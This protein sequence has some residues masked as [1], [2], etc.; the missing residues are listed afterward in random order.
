MP[1][2][3]GHGHTGT[4]VR[5][6]GLGGW[7]MD[8]LLL[9]HSRRD[10]S[11]GRVSRWRKDLESDGDIQPRPPGPC[12]HRWRR[13]SHRTARGLRLWRVRGA[14]RR[15][16]LTPA[17]STPGPLGGQPFKLLTGLQG[18]R[19]SPDGKRLVAMR[20]GAVRGDELIVADNDGGNP[21]A[22]RTVE[23]W[24]PCALACL[25]ARRS[26][27]LLRL[28]V[29]DHAGGADRTLSRPIQRKRNG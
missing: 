10:R 8:C 28:H 25:V 16:F 13:H 18:M 2:Y 7:K 19:W 14:M 20:P 29:H 21:Q 22:D 15:P 27:H 6:R 4:G 17:Q 1:R 3:Q 11:L 23:R 9:G 24:S 26:V 12:L 5:A